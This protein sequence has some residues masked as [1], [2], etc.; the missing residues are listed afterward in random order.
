[1]PEQKIPTQIDLRRRT[2]L[3]TMGLAVGSGFFSRGVWAEDKA[4]P[5]NAYPDSVVKYLRRIYDEGQVKFSYREDYPGG[6]EVW[7]KEAREELRRLIGLD[8]IVSDCGDHEPKVEMSEPGPDLGGY[9]RQKGL[10]ETEP[11]VR[12]PFWLLRPEGEG[13]FPLAILPHGHD[14]IGFDTYAGAAHDEEHQKRITERRADVA[15][16]AAQRGFV[17]IAP[18]TRGLSTPGVPDLLKRHGDLD[19]RSQL[20][21]CLLA[22]RTAIGERVWDMQRILDWEMTLNEVD[23]ERVLMMGNSGGGMVTLYASACDPRVSVAVPSCSFTLLH[24]RNGYI[25]HCDCNLVPGMAEWG[26][27]YDVAGP[28][29]P[30]PLL[31]VN[32]R[33]DTLHS[34]SDI[35][36]AAARAE[37]IYRASGHPENFES[38]FGGGGHRFYPELMWPFVMKAIS[39]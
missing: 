29:A 19:C 30:R 2:F 24:S 9:T 11:D 32:G 31:V 7:Q 38:K 23:S 37:A 8:R 17:A 25:Y 26:D 10:I 16:Q 21:H 12:I 15:V 34:V 39:A 36:K 1:M 3:K 20:I 28:I 5:F 22:G 6:F 14:S 18:A 33:E 4:D 35:E 13:P 27:L